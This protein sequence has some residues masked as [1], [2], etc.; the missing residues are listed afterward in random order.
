[1]LHRRSTVAIAALLALALACRSACAQSAE[2]AFGLWLNPENGSN[3][4]FYKCGGGGLCA[5]L[6]K[7]TDG[8]LTDDKNP[9]PGKRSQ[10]IVG[11]LIMENAKKTGANKW[12][13]MLYN[14]ENGKSYSGTLTVKTKDAVDLS[15]CVAAV[16]CRTV[17][18]TR[19]K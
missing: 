19:I 9:D 5:K 1:M 12:S 8:Q 7:V 3:I 6:T 18:W 16:L 17:T 14:R 4:E 11:L 13:G 15:G 2:D 10:P